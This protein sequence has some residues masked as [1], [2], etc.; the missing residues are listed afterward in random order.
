MSTARASSAAPTVA[1]VP[2]TI[3]LSKGIAD[4]LSLPSMSEC[5]FGRPTR[6]HVPVCDLIERIVRNGAV[7]QLA[8][9]SGGPYQ[10]RDGGLIQHCTPLV[11]LRHPAGKITC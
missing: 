3:G 7:S 11:Y 8:R 9:R 6:R 5:L 1:Q 10:L 4:Q 2:M